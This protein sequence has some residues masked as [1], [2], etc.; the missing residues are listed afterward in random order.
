MRG[1][2]LTEQVVNGWLREGSIVCPAC[3][4]L[5]GEQCVPGE[6]LA[7]VGDAPLAEPCAAARLELPAAALLLLLFGRALLPLG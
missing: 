3:A 5:C 6:Q 1:E 7:E 4:D 2:Q